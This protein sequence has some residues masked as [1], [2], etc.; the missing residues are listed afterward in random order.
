M[1]ADKTGQQARISDY[2]V[3]AE[4]YCWLLTELHDKGM[5]PKNWREETLLLIVQIS[6]DRF[7]A[8][9]LAPAAS[10]PAAGGANRA[11]RVPGCEHLAIPARSGPSLVQ[12]PNSW[13]HQTE[14]RPVPRGRPRTGCPGH[15]AQSAP[16]CARRFH[17][18]AVGNSVMLPHAS[19]SARQTTT[20]LCLAHA[21]PA[22]LGLIAPNNRRATRRGSKRT[23]V[24]M[25]KD[26]I[27]P[28]FAPR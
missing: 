22:C 3:Y 18:G 19:V 1:V 23:D 4:M 28:L 11:G 17:L 20:E 9:T 8:S 2:V 15:T 14:V 7:F 25:R 10:L 24:P 13:M 16:P 12:R 6:P 21:A 26:G 27:A 5:Q